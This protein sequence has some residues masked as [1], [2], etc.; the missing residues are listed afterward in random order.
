MAQQTPCTILIVDDEPSVVIALAELLRRQ[1][2][3][4]ATASNGAL[5]LEY[6]HAQPYDVILCDL[7]MP[8]I[9]GQ[10][11]YTTLQRDYPSLYPRVIFLTGDTVG[12]TSTAF[13]QQCGQPWLYKPFGASEVLHAIAQVLR[14][15]DG[16][17]TA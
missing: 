1:G 12:A 15:A 6:L 17:Y 11:F 3:T 14:A 13:L 2:Y 4:V 5:A 9:D 16:P 8:E 10:T 7:L